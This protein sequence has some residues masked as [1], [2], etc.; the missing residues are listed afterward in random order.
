MELYDNQGSSTPLTA[1][2]EKAQPERAKQKE[3]TAQA[4]LKAVF[5]FFALSAAR[6]M[7]F[8]FFEA[9]PTWGTPSETRQSPARQKGFFHFEAPHSGNASQS[10]AITPYF[11][12]QK[13]S[14]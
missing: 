8:F 11:S 9:T 2:E 13:L 10:E 14:Q 3:K 5:I 6:Q 4:C 1:K 7:G 12:H